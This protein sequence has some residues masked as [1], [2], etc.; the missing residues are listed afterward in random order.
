VPGPGHALTL[1]LR[2][3]DRSTPDAKAALLRQGVAGWRQDLAPGTRFARDGANS[4]RTRSPDAMMKPASLMIITL[5]TLSTATAAVDNDIQSVE[6]IRAAAEA[7]VVAPHDDANVSA[8]AGRLDPRLRLPSCDRPLST[9][10]ATAAA[11]GG[12]QSVGVRCEGSRNWTIYVPVK[13]SRRARVVVLAR[14][15]QRDT[16]L[17]PEHLDMVTRDVAGLSSGFFTQAEELVG[18]RV[19]RSAAAGTVLTPVLVHRP[20]LIERGD[21]VTL[22]SGSSAVAVSAPAEALGAGRRGERLRVR[23]LSS[24]KVIEAVVVSR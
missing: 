4:C 17:T 16:L 5:I 20:P 15:V 12:N 8:R 6:S 10:A 21:R 22:A 3:I 7:F 2:P 11:A 19:K 1:P 23:N 18:H 13:V 14:T 24:G 9:F